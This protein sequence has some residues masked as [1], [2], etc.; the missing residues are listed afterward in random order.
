[1]TTVLV[2]APATGTQK[3][4]KT[5]RGMSRNPPQR[6]KARGAKRRCALHPGGFLPGCRE[7]RPRR[8]RGGVTGTVAASLPLRQDGNPQP[9]G[10]GRD[11]EAGSVRSMTADRTPVARTETVRKQEMEE[12]EGVTG[13]L[14]D[15]WRLSGIMPD[16][17][18]RNGNAFLY[19]TTLYKV[20]F[21]PWTH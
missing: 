1:M 17:N 4:E 11:G 3:G 13:G 14:T 5:R 12:Y 20:S 10:P 6:R 19:C 2:S 21:P 7:R 16:W 8:D 15:G 18:I 9:E